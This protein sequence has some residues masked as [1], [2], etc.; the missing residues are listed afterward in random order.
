MINNSGIWIECKP[1]VMVGKPCVKGTRITVESI[2]EMLSSGMTYGEIISDF[3]SLDEIKI[4]AAIGY[5]AHH[6]SKGNAA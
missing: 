5:A 2:L 6:L 1:D 3:P 4:R